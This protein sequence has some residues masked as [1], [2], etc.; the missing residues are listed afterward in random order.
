ME[1][2]YPQRVACFLGESRMYNGLGSWKGRERDSGPLE[3]SLHE[4]SKTSEVAAY[5]RIH[6][7]R[8]EKKKGLTMGET[9]WS[10][11][12][13]GAPFSF[14]RIGLK[15]LITDLINSELILVHNVDSIHGSHH[16]HIPTRK[17]SALRRY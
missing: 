10:H 15:H 8:I 13:A 14:F 3:L 11:S 5:D 7:N 6:E 16:I 4:R 2:R 1:T 9:A 12:T 17:L